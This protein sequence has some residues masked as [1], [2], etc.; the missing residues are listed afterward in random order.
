M[1]ELRQNMATKEWYVIATERAKRPHDFLTGREKRT[2]PPYLESCPFCPGNEHMTPP[3][4]FRIARGD[5]WQV[6]VVPNKFSAFSSKGTPERRSDGIYR[7]MTG[8]GIHEVI[9]ESPRH[10]LG[11]ALMPEEDVIDVMRAYR[12]RYI[13]A[14]EDPRVELVIIFKNHG[15]GAGTSLEHPHSQLIAIPLVPT[16]IM[17]RTEEARRFY[18]DNGACVFCKMI[19]EEKRSDKRI[20]MENDHFIVFTPYASGAPFEMWILPKRHQACF[21]FINDDELVW[22]ARTLKDVLS[23]LYYGLGDPDFNYVIRTTP[24]DERN[25]KGFHWYIKLMPKLVQ[26]AGFE[27]GTGMYVNVTLPEKNAEFLKNVKV[28][29]G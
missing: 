8:V 13:S 1:S 29:E 10:D 5:S 22:L 21:A 23:R 27:L 15:P 16:H 12:A 11:I 3:E 19:E 26:V 17:Y 7:T 4:T 2:K 14:I 18:N 24:K 28:P 25:A 6:R 20:V 9:I